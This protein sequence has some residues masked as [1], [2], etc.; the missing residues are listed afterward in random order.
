MNRPDAEVRFTGMR[1]GEKLNETLFSEHE[2]PHHTVHPRIFRTLG[3]TQVAGF[4]RQL[5]NLYDAAS[6]NDVDAVRVYLRG[7]LPDYHPVVPRVPAQAS[8]PYADDY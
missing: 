1:P 2:E 8:A 5:R 4:H 7:L 3:Q 6:R